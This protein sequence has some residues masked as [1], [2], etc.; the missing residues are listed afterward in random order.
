M[1]DIMSFYNMFEKVMKT[2]C[3]NQL[4]HR[5][6]DVLIEDA[7]VVKDK[8]RFPCLIEQTIQIDNL[9][10]IFHHYGIKYNKIMLYFPGGAFT[11]PPT[12]FHYKFAKKLARKTKHHV[13][14]VQY[15]LFPEVDPSITTSLLRKIIKKLNLKEFSII[16]DS[17]GANLATYLLLSYHKDNIDIINKIILVSPFIDSSM[18]NP[19]IKLI[20]SDDFILNKNNCFK[21]GKAL[22]SKC[23]NGNMYLFPKEDEFKFKSNVLLISGSNEIF[24]PDIIKWGISQNVL[25]VKHY[26]YNKM[27]HCFTIFPIKEARL[28]LK[29][30][31]SFLQEN[32]DNK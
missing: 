31:S 16:G 25:K 12:I 4:F 9:D 6:I 10:F 18:D 32:I 17:A 19:Y 21:M 22:Y 27:C 11:D 13:I 30:I 20:D 3:N 15:P 14:M 5:P 24:T 23:L 1:G 29:D 8:Y 2:Y 28:A 26:V 7:Q